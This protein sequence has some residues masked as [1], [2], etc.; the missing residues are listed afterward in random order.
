MQPGCP[1]LTLEGL[2]AAVMHDPAS[3]PLITPNPRCRGKDLKG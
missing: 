2:W 1:H 3:L